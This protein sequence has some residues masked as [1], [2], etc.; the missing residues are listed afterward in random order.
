MYNIINDGHRWT[1]EDQFTLESQLL[2]A[3]EEPLCLDPSPA[4][5]LVNNKLQYEQ[6]SLCNPILKRSEFEP[7][8]GAQ[9]LNLLIFCRT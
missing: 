5:L 2:L 3:T 1:Q 4:V 9:L 7:L 8:T 6:K